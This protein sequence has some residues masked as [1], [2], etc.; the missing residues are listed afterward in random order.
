MR[1]GLV[2]ILSAFVVT[3]AASPE[4]FPAETGKSR[5][6]T[7]ENSM[8]QV[9]RPAAAN[10]NSPSNRAQPANPTAESGKLVIMEFSDLECPDS[11][12]Y[13]SGL[14]SE[15]INRFVQSGAASYE[16]HD[17]PL[18]AHP[19]ARQAAATARCA[20]DKVS[21]VR[22]AILQGGG[23][24]QAALQSA[25]VNNAQVQQCIQSGST[26]RQVDADRALGQS[27]GVRGTPTLVL[28]Y[29]Q[30]DGTVKAVKSLRPDKNPQTIV[31]EISQLIKQ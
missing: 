26:L 4:E 22:A 16:F 8:A 25:G 19:N 12:R 5:A 9:E 10:Q 20:G 21:A 23:N 14:K 18:D 2:A 6:A 29:K 24:V 31:S 13:S 15:I 28:G 30:A 1:H 17:F 7:G 11:A 27:L 3:A